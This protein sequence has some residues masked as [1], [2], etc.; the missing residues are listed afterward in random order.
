MVVA[1]TYLF[2]S[3]GFTSQSDL[4]TAGS[5]AFGNTIFRG[6]Y[7]PGMADQGIGCGFVSGAVED[8]RQEPM[9]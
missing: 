2:V 6:H 3:T 7:A 1:W 8:K 9:R 5:A 4:T